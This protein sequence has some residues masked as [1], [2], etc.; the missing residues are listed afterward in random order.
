MRTRQ[1][2]LFGK[3]Y[4]VNTNRIY[5]IF[6]LVFIVTAMLITGHMDYHSGVN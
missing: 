4:R 5:G 6:L 1:V 3:R 2:G